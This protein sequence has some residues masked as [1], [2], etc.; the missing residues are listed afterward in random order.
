MGGVAVPLAEF[1]AHHR[2]GA[3]SIMDDYP[4]AHAGL[5]TAS[6]AIL[7]LDRNRLAGRKQIFR[8]QV[9]LRLHAVRRG[10]HFSRTLLGRHGFSLSSNHPRGQHLPTPDE[11]CYFSVRVGSDVWCV[12]TN[13]DV[14][15]RSAP[16]ASHCLIH[17]GKLSVS[18]ASLCLPWGSWATQ[19]RFGGSHA[20]FLIKERR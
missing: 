1:E 10:R 7:A 14:P 17:S 12:P 20:S 4:A 2:W 18:I 16:C 9:I 11:T 5:M 3:L 19:R 13:C 15:G 6:A 8:R